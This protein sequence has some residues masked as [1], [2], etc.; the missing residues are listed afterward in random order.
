MV[1]LIGICLTCGNCYALSDEEIFNIEQEKAQNGDAEA[2]TFVG[3]MY[4]HGQG[5][6]QDYKKAFEWYEKAA[7]QGVPQ[8]QVILGAMYESGICVRQD[9]HIAKEWYGKACDNGY[10]DGCDNYRKLNEAEYYK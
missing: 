1:V 7:I 10:Q 4:E 2:Q 8:A 3:Y 5:V 6:K 9:K